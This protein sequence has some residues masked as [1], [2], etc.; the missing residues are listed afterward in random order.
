[1]RDLYK[2]AISNKRRAEEIQD[3]KDIKEFVDGRRKNSKDI[4]QK[5][6][7]KMMRSTFGRG[8]LKYGS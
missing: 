8:L 6:R 4:S 2:E 7:K 3:E 1:M 5:Q